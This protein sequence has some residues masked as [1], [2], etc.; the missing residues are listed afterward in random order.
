MC[1][2]GVFYLLLYTCVQ[3]A[4]QL[5]VAWQN[6]KLVSCKMQ[7]FLQ[8]AASFALLYSGFCMNQYPSVLY[9]KTQPY[10]FPIVGLCFFFFFFFF[11]QETGI[12]KS[13]YKTLQFIIYA[14]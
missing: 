13:D 14:C 8:N 9:T 7:A 5:T 4:I 10:I 1:I 12:E 11:V 3:Y 6:S 2:L